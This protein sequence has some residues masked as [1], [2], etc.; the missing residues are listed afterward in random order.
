MLHIPHYRTIANM[1]ERTRE[2]EIKAHNEVERIRKS[3]LSGLT[4]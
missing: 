4:V 2:R 3:L 1:N